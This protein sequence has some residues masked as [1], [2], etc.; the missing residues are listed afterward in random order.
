MA[1][2]GFAEAVEESDRN[3]GLNNSHMLFL[4]QA[5]LLHGEWDCFYWGVLRAGYEVVL[6][7]VSSGLN[8]AL[9]AAWE[10][11]LGKSFGYRA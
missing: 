7:H 10:S 11:L 4:S 5:S 3:S 6:P 8:T 9:P 1:S 2:K